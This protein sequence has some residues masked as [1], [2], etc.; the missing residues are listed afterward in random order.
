M[1]LLDPWQFYAKVL[2]V[3]IVIKEQNVTQYFPKNH[4]DICVLSLVY[5]FT[6][7]DIIKKCPLSEKW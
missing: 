5:E 1:K 4:N 2:F 6:S 3:W 7:F